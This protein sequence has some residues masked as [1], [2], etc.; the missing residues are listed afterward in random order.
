MARSC[1]KSEAKPRKEK[2][3]F[4]FCRCF[5]CVVPYG[6]HVEGSS[7]PADCWIERPSTWACGPL[8][9]H[10]HRLIYLVGS[11]DALRAPGRAAR[12][13]GKVDQTEIRYM[14]VVELLLASFKLAAAAPL[15]IH[16]PTPALV[17]PRRRSTLHLTDL[18]RIDP[19]YRSGGVREWGISR[20]PET[21]T[22][23]PIT[24]TRRR[25]D[26]WLRCCRST[27]YR[28]VWCRVRDQSTDGCDQP[29]DVI[30]QVYQRLS[31]SSVG[32]TYGATNV[33]FKPNQIQPESS[34]RTYTG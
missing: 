14:S 28:S 29:M 8:R 24:T 11:V 32:R 6:P 2:S 9:P 16:T 13:L 22:R 7:L 34:T 10:D 27:T 5:F 20:R 12:A 17:L 4:D 31:G 23:S 3:D 26:A 21:R 1:T 15:I 30:D 33:R 19:S 25:E 18:T